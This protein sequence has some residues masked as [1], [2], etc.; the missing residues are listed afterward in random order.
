MT[1]YNL[2]VDLVLEIVS[3]TTFKLILCCLL[4][5]IQLE[6]V[7]TAKRT[8]SVSTL[9]VTLDDHHVPISFKQIGNMLIVKKKYSDTELR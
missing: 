8:P 2:G 1:D 9:L 3:L 6:T 7:E 4:R 5:N